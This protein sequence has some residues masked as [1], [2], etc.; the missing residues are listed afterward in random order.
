MN[1]I[2]DAAINRSR[3]VLLTLAM[4]LITGLYSYISIPKES[5]P[6]INIPIIYVSL[7]LRGISPEDAERLLIRPVEQ[8]LRSVEGVKEMRSTGFL[9]GA[10]VQLE[11]EAGFDA[12]QALDDVREKVDEVK[13]ELPEEA[14]EPTVH[15]VN[16]S[17]FPIITV[18]L[19]GSA[20]ERTLLRLA[21]NL[22]DEIESL[23]SVLEVDI[24]GDRDEQVEVI[25]DPMRVESYQ[26][27]S[28]QILNNIRNFNTLVAAGSI[29]TGQGGF[30]IKVPGLFEKEED[31]MNMP[32][33]VSG[34]A[35]ARIKDIAE[36]RRTFVDPL[37][38]AFYNGE[39]AITLEVKKRTGE[40][41]IQTIEDTRAIVNRVSKH[42]PSTVKVDF[43]GDRSK[44]IRT[45]LTDLQNNVIS[46]ILLVMIVVVAALGLR[47]AGLVGISI[48]GSFL[49]G[50][51]V[52]Y[53]M[54]LTV[55]IVVL[56]S[57]ILSVG[58]LVDGAIV[59]TEY[60]DVKLHQGHTP[61]EAYS[62]AAKR[63]AWPI[64]AS[65]ATTLAAFCPLLFWPGVLG[66]FMKFMPITLLATLSAS[67]LM[68]L[69]FVPVLGKTFTRTT[70]N[71]DDDKG[72]FD[73]FDYVTKYYVRVLDKCLNHANYIVLGAVV[74]LISIF[75]IYGKYGK[76]SELFPETE[77]DLAVV[78]V[79]A[80]GN[81][82]VHE[83]KQLVAEI[84]KIVLK[85]REETGEIEAAYSRSGELGENDAAEDIIGTIQVRFGDWKSRRTAA[86][87]LQEIV[88]L[89]KAYPGLKVDAQKMDEG[90]PVG[91]PI[92]ILLS[93]PDNKMREKV[94]QMIVKKLSSM[95][96]VQNIEDGSN[97]PGIEWE[98][99][100]DR[101]QAVKFGVD[102]AFVGNFIQMIT[103]GAELTTFRPDNSNDE[104]SI[105]ARYPEKYR[106][107]RQLDNVRI[108]TP[109]GNIPIGNFVTKTAKPKVGLITRTDGARS[110]TVKAD[111]QEGILANEKLLEVQEWLKK[112]DIP[113]S[114]NIK[115]K[116]EDEEQKK[117]AAF[118]SKA[119][120]IA[121]FLITII[122]V[123]QFN[124][125]YSAFLILTAVIMS[126]IGVFIGLLLTGQ[127]FG[128]VM[129]G[130]GVIALAGIVVNNNIVLIDTFDKEM[131]RAKTQREAIMETG[132]QRLRPVLLTTI[133]TI[134]GLMPMVLQINIDFINR[135]VDVGAPSTQWW[136]QLSTSIVFGLTFATILTLIVT[137]CLLM[138]R[139][140]ASDFRD[141]RR[142]LKAKKLKQAK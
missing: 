94:A 132:K 54:G 139:S 22:R 45:M 109:D 62:M 70:P 82:S 130:V 42:W 97:I 55:N 83:K 43:Y 111:V 141:K 61:S 51:L 60:A 136:V 44:D 106:N 134:L 95:E 56:F 49:T 133:T 72:K 21:R 23:S 98:L 129:S 131:L 100:V 125:F 103:N 30:N 137:P 121:V 27:G 40:N 116:G 32:F 89:A 15:E 124:R 34:D 71:F 14:E 110:Q 74:L 39:R 138:L 88:E 20:P 68:A 120:L 8:K 84:E 35:T 52:I 13:P 11:F 126:T 142:A 3:T 73:F 87:I 119:F 118:L 81:F 1:A 128:I 140:N 33:Q 12:D 86:E 36:V 63:M 31:V 10:N 41:V 64:T 7:E 113:P 4:L 29:D 59:L 114:V 127:P 78:Q 50:I 67:L 91:K 79:H 102:I 25:V 75:I 6:D 92:E 47:S 2:I 65:T 66:E 135:V 115:F 104:I 26:I 38:F 85:K 123:T 90:P 117:A 48:P 58:M 24:G 46:A 28:S 107:I 53:S 101:A 16:L 77:P 37:G 57:L 80:R 18:V 112:Q 9:G 69:I 96:G 19:S 5:S 108:S 76:G 93:S 99:T 105:V 122:L 17:L